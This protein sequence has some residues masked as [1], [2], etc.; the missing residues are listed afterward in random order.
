MSGY[1]R[2]ILILISVICGT[3]IYA[4]Q[5]IVNL[6]KNIE[7]LWGVEKLRGYHTLIEY[8]VENQPK[9]ASRYVRRAEDLTETIIHPSNKLLEAGDFQLKPKTYL[10]AGQYYEVR[11]FYMESK[12]AYQKALL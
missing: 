1:I 3:A 4:Q 2:S 11:G 5:D 9:K 12:T 10:L 8:Y 6:E 7:D